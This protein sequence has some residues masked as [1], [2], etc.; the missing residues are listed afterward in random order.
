MVTRRKPD[1]FHGQSSQGQPGYVPRLFRWGQTRAPPPEEKW[2]VADANWSPDGRKIVF[3]SCE[4]TGT[5]GGP[6]LI[7]I[8]DLGSHQVTKLP[9]SDRMSSPRW[10]PD[11]RFIAALS[12]VGGP[13]VYDLETKQW[14][15][16]LTGSPVNYFPT[17]SHDSR[18][19]YFLG[20]VEHR[21]VYGV[22]RIPVSGG[23]V[24][25]ISDLGGLPITGWLGVGWMGL[26]PTDAPL[27]LR[28]VGSK[29][30]YALTLEEK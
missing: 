15:V 21:N 14:S 19:I 28:D 16:L 27:V 24:E 29:D 4:C 2:T 30:L 1:P 8:L 12:H 26:D 22:F 13:R 23:K 25:T 18:W 17:F 20:V 6:D 3:A 5:S 10:S 7:R 11:G 9:G